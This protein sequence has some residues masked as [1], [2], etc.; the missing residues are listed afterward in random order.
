LICC[1]NC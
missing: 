1:D